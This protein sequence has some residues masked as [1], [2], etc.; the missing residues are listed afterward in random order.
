MKELCKYRHGFGIAPYDIIKDNN[1]KSY[2]KM[3]L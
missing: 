1:D 2:V 3:R